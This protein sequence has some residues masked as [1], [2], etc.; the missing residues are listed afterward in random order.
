MK[1][2]IFDTETT[3]VMPWVDRII[4]FGWIFWELNEETWEFE[5]L[6]SL[7]QLVN[8]DERIPE[9]ATAVHWIT[10]EDLIWYDYID[11]Y[12]YKF[13][14]LVYEADYVVGHN[15]AFD[16]WMLLGEAKRLW[17]PFDV[18]RVKW[19]DTMRP[20]SELVNW[21]WWRWPKLSAL[22]EFLFWRGFENAHDAL[23]DVK[24]TKDCFVELCKSY[25]FYENGCFKEKLTRERKVIDSLNICNELYNKISD[26]S[27]Y[28][29]IAREN[30]RENP[31][32]LELL[33][34][35][36]WWKKSIFLT[37]KAWTGK[38]TLMKWII[39]SCELRDLHPI[40][41]GSTG[42]SA[43][44]IW[45]STIHSFFAMG[46]DSIY[47]QDDAKMRK[48]RLWKDKVE[49]IKEAPFLIIDEISM[50]HSNT[51]DVIDR[52]L[53][54]YL[55][56]SRPFGWK[57]MLFV[58]D[59]YQLPPVCNDEWIDNFSDKYKSEWFFHSD[60]FKNL[61][62]DVIE[63]TINY[64]QWEDKLLS[65]ILDHIRDNCISENDIWVLDDCRHHELGED[66]T[67]LYTHKRDVARHNREMLD[68]LK[69]EE[70]VIA[71]EVWKE[72]P[73]NMMPNSWEDVVIKVGAKVMM[74][75]NDPKGRW[76]N[77]SIWFV[78]EINLFAPKPCLIIDIEWREERVEK[79]LWRYAPMRLNA[80]WKYEEKTLGTYLQFPI[81]L[82]YA[83]TVHKSQGLTF[84]E[85]IMNIE[86]V[87]VWGQ[88]YTALSRVKSLK[89]LKILWRVDK[90]KLYFDTRI[91]DFKRTVAIKRLWKKIVQYLP[92]PELALAYTKVEFIEEIP[93][94]K[95]SISD[96][97][98]ILSVGIE[99][100]HSAIVRKY[101]ELLGS[102]VELLLIKEEKA[103]NSWFYD[104]GLWS[105]DKIIPKI[106]LNEG[107]K[108]DEEE[109]L[110]KLKSLRI[111]LAKMEWF[112]KIFWICS[113]ETL[114]WVAKY[115]PCNEEQLS[116]MKGFWD[117]KVEK[118][119]EYFIQLVESAWYSEDDFI[120]P[121]WVKKK[122]KVKTS[123]VSEKDVEVVEN[124]I[125]QQVDIANKAHLAVKLWSMSSWDRKLYE[126]L[127]N[128][129]WKIW[130]HDLSDDDLLVLVEEKPFRE[131][132]FNE[133]L[134][135]KAIQWIE[136]YCEAIENFLNEDL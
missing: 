70:Y 75:T 99:K 108:L 26:S 72:Y 80:Q 54:N 121:L 62:Y 9:W 59:I 28:K 31:E 129:R 2:F 114:E 20:T 52:L 67:V 104:I 43:L 103:E 6:Y 60:V 50:V 125:T 95:V 83:I 127:N 61:V 78:E 58:W 91:N 51:L 1:V 109:L 55:R 96:Y 49:M 92:Q 24:A 86:N 33:L 116:M 85:S 84:E 88:A 102:E 90:Y 23:G 46:K 8:I 135:W 130:H 48:I 16:R 101:V 27:I 63:L 14:A 40:I 15:I 69:W 119:W 21:V 132:M 100:Y 82:A 131:E 41:L 76:V 134:G 68:R 73:D 122:S 25:W 45:W 118:Y 18:E 56:D 36:D 10:N 64:R 42:I 29:E 3:W 105:A 22:H 34:T 113:N 65:T 37:G 79:H 87:F 110:K 120:E 35:L 57:Q 38:S 97:Y 47:Y 53:R 81:Q 98:D 12:I 39:K 5:E 93:A 117:T 128:L 13:L 89:G 115:R 136:K 123:W 7:N 74:V 17:I 19:V 124:T 111:K 107:E 30:W 126:I 44:N 11:R 32:A 77:W 112:S 66:A 94:I 133:V 4:Q 106:K 71:W